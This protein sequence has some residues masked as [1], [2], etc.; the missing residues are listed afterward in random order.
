MALRCLWC[1]TLSSRNDITILISKSGQPFKIQE[2]SQ[3]SMVPCSPWSP[4]WLDIGLLT[5]SIR[6]LQMAFSRHGGTTPEILACGRLRQENHRE[7]QGIM[8][9]KVR[10]CVLKKNALKNYYHFLKNNYMP[11]LAA[12]SKM[13]W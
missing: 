4:L 7:L 11:C 5:N 6:N 10:P 9:Y 13:V 2:S 1:R 3:L 8:I 12:V